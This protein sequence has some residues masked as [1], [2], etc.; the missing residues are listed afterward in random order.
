MLPMDQA[1]FMALSMHAFNT[2]Q[3]STVS[4]IGICNMHFCLNKEDNTVMNANRLNCDAL[5]IPWSASENGKN[6]KIHDKTL[7]RECARYMPE[8]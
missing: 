3:A 5:V 4:P 7:G 8:Q 6:Q 2:M 1:H